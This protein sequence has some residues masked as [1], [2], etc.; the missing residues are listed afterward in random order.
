MLLTFISLININIAAS[1]LLLFFCSS[2]KSTQTSREIGPENSKK[3]RKRKGNGS[4]ESASPETKT[5]CNTATPQ[6]T[7]SRTQTPLTYSKTKES[8]ATKAKALTK[9]NMNLKIAATKRKGPA[10]DLE[11]PSAAREASAK[12]EKPIVEHTKTFSWNSNVRGR[13]DEPSPSIDDFDRSSA[14]YEVTATDLHLSS[15]QVETKSDLLKPKSATGRTG[16]TTITVEPKTR[17]KTTQKRSTSKTQAT[18]NSSRKSAKLKNPKKKKQSPKKSSPGKTNDAVSK[19]SATAA[20]AGT[21]KTSTPQ[22]LTDQQIDV[23]MTQSLDTVET[24]E[25][26]MDRPET[27]TETVKSKE[28]IAKSDP[29]KIESKSKSDP[30]NLESKSSSG[31]SKPKQE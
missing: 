28:T 2:K 26:T 12:E 13:K 20:T 17:T 21:S 25:T 24:V 19:A 9:R 8:P 18:Q 6:K 29:Q 22:M 31:P 23:M 14:L 1:T 30:Q 10:E 15:T 4:H 27:E 11:E 3:L 16:T 5:P 7:R